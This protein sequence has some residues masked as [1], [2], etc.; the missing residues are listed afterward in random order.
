MPPTPMVLI[1]K[2]NFWSFDKDVFN[3]YFFKRGLSYKLSQCPRLCYNVKVSSD[4]FVIYLAKSLV[5]IYLLDCT[6]I[7]YL[8][9][10][11]PKFLE[12]PRENTWYGNNFRKVACNLH[13]IMQLL[14]VVNLFLKILGNSTNKCLRRTPEGLLMNL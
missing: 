10:T 4:F 5:R 3:A 6:I 14:F 11:L 9:N 2:F 7:Y 13:A 8:K 12:K 1:N